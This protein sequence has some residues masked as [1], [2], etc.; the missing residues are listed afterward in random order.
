[1]TFERGKFLKDSFS[2]VFFPSKKSWICRTFSSL[3]AKKE[4]KAKIRV[5]PKNLRERVSR[6]R[7]AITHRELE[8]QIKRFLR[9]PEKEKKGN[10]ENEDFETVFVP[11]S[12]RQ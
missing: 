6:L 9:V 4:N 10:E 3:K 8:K 5:I 7:G 2:G 1:M 11:L 12:N